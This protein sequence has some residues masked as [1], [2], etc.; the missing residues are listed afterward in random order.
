MPR[1]DLVTEVPIQKPET[2]RRMKDKA[3]IQLPP[4]PQPDTS[5]SLQ[6][7]I[8]EL[9]RKKFY[10]YEYFVGTFN[11]LLVL[12]FDQTVNVDDAMDDIA[13]Q[14]K[15]GLMR[16]VVGSPSTSYEPAFSVTTR[17]LY[18]N[19]DDSNKLGLRQST[20]E[21][22]NGFSVNEEGDKDVNHMAEKV[23]SS[24]QV[25]GWHSD[26]EL[27]LNGIPPRVVK[28][29]EDVQ[30]LDFDST[31]GLRV[32]SESHGV[33]RFPEASLASTSVHKEGQIEVPPEWTPPNLSVPV[34]NLVDKLFQLKRRGWLRRQVFWISK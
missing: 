30:N 28:C 4:K 31:S 11:S 23:D 16:T 3:P 15:G 33:S 17:N 18:W 20:S 8:L 22:I 32:Q 26:N 27:D 29:N 10:R 13:H 1:K 34:L 2:S 6:H 14:I 25:S 7:I 9:T 19:S 21:S 12:S 24:A 5:C